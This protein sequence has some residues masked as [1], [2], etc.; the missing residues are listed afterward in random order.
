MLRRM[1][2]P[3]P[4]NLFELTAQLPDHLF[5]LGVVIASDFT[6]QVLPSA[7]DGIPFLVEETANLPDQH[8]VMTLIVPAISTAFY[9]LEIRKF[10]LP[11]TQHVWLDVTQVADLANGEIPFIRYCR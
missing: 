1:K 3:N 9:R 4:D 11:I 10:L 2:F 5:G 8:D 7:T 6:G